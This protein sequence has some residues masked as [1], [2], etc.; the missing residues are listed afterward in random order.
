MFHSIFM[1]YGICV[2]GRINV[3]KKIDKSK[4]R[5]QFDFALVII[6]ATNE[7]HC[8]PSPD[9]CLVHSFRSAHGCP[10]ITYD[11]ELAR[12][13]QSWASHLAKIGSLQHS[14]A[15]GYGEN[16]AYK[17]SSAQASLSGK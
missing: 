11:A 13:A 9:F 1:D 17:W 7:R 12:N 8:C 16:L 6:Y 14:K 15:Q 2:S 4:R 10:K 3:E 5:I